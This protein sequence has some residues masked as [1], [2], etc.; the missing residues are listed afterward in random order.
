MACTMAIMER[1]QNMTNTW[2]NSIFSA[3]EKTID[4]CLEHTGK[5]FFEWSFPR[6]CGVTQYFADKISHDLCMGRSVVVFGHNLDN[7]NTIRERVARNPHLQARDLSIN[8]RKEIRLESGGQALFF[9]IKTNPHW[10]LNIR[11]RSLDRVYLDNWIHT[12]SPKERQEFKE[13]YYPVIA[14]GYGQKY[15][16][17]LNTTKG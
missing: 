13:C 5:R 6:Q 3:V 1:E 16:L 7:A 14:S 10:M 9:T 8:N 15:I 11:G 4:S 2:D 12:T 17:A